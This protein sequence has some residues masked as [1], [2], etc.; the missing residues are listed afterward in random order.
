MCHIKRYIDK[1]EF[2]GSYEIYLVP[3]IDVSRVFE[4][5]LN[6]QHGIVYVDNG[7]IKETPCGIEFYTQYDE[8]FSFFAGDIILVKDENGKL[9]WGSE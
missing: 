1:K 9:L 8:P 4:L 6:Y 3:D 5:G 7:K 2:E